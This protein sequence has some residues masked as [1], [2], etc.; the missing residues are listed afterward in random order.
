MIEGDGMKIGFGKIEDSNLRSGP[1]RP[2]RS[3]STSTC[4]STISTAPPSGCVRSEPADRISS[5]A[6]TGGGCCS[7]PTASRSA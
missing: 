6:P 5:P 2:R 4:K 3:A 7:I 1:T